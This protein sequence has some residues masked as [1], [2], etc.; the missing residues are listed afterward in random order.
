MAI[1]LNPGL[2]RSA[3][4]WAKSIGSYLMGWFSLPK[5]VKEIK[6]RLAAGEGNDAKSASRYYCDSC[7]STMK[8]VKTKPYVD[9]MGIVGA[10]EDVE[11][12]FLQCRD[13]E[14]YRH[15]NHRRLKVVGATGE[16]DR[17]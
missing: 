16:L 10:F 14:C 1:H 6:A 9:E 4:G 12:V 11:W 13:T 8:I 5:E 2:I 7:S 3:W 15:N 17:E